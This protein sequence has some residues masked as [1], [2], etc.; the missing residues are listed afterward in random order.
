MS[1]NECG[2]GHDH[3]DHTT[4]QPSKS[5]IIRANTSVAL[6]SFLQGMAK[7]VSTYEELTGAKV[8]A[9]VAITLTSAQQEGIPEGTLAVMRA[10]YARNLRVW[11]T[12]NQPDGVKEEAS[13]ISAFDTSPTLLT[14]VPKNPDELLSTVHQNTV[15][16]KE[17]PGGP[18]TVIAGLALYSN[19][20]DKM[21]AG[22]EEGQLTDG[23]F[24]KVSKVLGV[25]TPK[26]IINGDAK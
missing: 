21:L 25:P 12:E 10:C 14:Y 7:L 18:L 13:M 3:H 16:Y 19:D 5:P 4:D 2:C 17:L 15:I 22:L 11:D 20:V 1:S 9:N 23:V 24:D 8:A 26:N 6:K